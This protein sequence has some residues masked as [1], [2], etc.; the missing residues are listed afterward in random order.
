MCED[1]VAVILVNYNGRVYNEKCIQSILSS[2][3]IAKLQVVVVDNA[4]SDG[5]LQ[6]LQVRFE[7]DERVQLIALEDNYGFARGNNEGI[8]WAREKGF[9]FFLLLNND[10]EIAPYAI[11]HMLSLQKKTDSIV[12]PKILYADQR[13]I[14]WCAGGKLTPVIRKAVQCGCNQKD[15]GQYDQDRDCDFAN[16]CCLLLTD[17]IIQRIGLLDEDFFLYYEDTEYSMRAAKAGIKICYCYEARVYHKVNGSTMGNASP[18]N[19]Y[20]ISRN[21]LMCNHK[22]LGRK[23]GL[24]L[25][26]YALNRCAWMIIWLLQGKTRMAGAVLQGIKDYRH[27]KNG[28]Y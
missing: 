17:G 14:I 11:C 21:W 15:V 9:R 8:K 10:T 7:N 19:A 26:Y 18:A 22:Y 3:G 25:A 20:Y 16:G 1:A 13:D 6:E 23:Y 24:F 5:S 4:S 2:K 12:V 28:K 27:G